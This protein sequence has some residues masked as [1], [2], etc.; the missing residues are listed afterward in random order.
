MITIVLML[1]IL[2]QL[3]AAAM[4]LRLIPLT[5]KRIAWT[6]IAAALT[7]MAL[8]RSI[9]FYRLLSGSITI[10]P[11]FGAEI[12]ALSISILMVVGISKI[13]PIF[14]AGAKSKE[15]LEKANRE[16]ETIFEAIGHSALILDPRHRIIAANR[17]ILKA[18]G[19]TEKEVLGRTCH[20]I[21]H[22]G[23]VSP[24]EHCPANKMTVSGRMEQYD[25]EID[26]LGGVF[27]VT[28]TPV[29]D[30][31]GQIRKIIH[32]ATDI[33]ERKR[34]E[35]KLREAYDII[36]GSPVVAFLWKNDE[37]W[38]VEFVT[39]NVKNL[40]GYEAEELTSGTV[41]YAETVHPDD[42]ETVIRE[43]SDYSKEK[44]RVA[45]DHK[46]YRI[47]TKDGTIKWVN[48][49]T[50]IRRNEKGEITYYQ[51]ILFDITESKR[52]ETALRES[53]IKYRSLVESSGDL[54]YAT[55]RKG[56]LTYVN[57]TLEKILG[58]DRGQLK[59]TPFIRITAPGFIDKAKEIFKQAMRGEN[60]PV[61]EGEL[62]GKDGTRIIVEFNTT[63]LFDSD[64]TFSGR[65]GIGRDITERRKMERA[66]LQ[67][68][69]RYKTYVENSFAGVYVVQKGR[70]V[71]LNNNA[72]SFVGYRPEEL[73]G[74][75]PE[76]IV[77]PE[78]RVV[79]R[80]RAIKALKEKETLPY[81]FRVVTKDGRI[82]WIME[83]VTSI[84]YDGGSAVLGNSMDI[85]ERKEAEE[86]LGIREELEKSI[87]LSVPHA[88]FGVEKRRIFFANAAMEDVFGWKPEELIG[89][90]TRVIFRNDEEWE[91]YDSMIYSG[92]KEMPV[93]RFESDMPFVRKD[94]SEIY[95]RTSVSRVG[96]EL[97][98]TGRIVA[99]FEDVT[100]Q[101]KADEERKKLE[102][103]LH[104]AQKMEAIGTLAGGIAHDF[105]NLLMT[106]QGNASMMLEDVD[107][108][109][110]FYEYLKSI[111]KQIRSAANLTRQL[112]GFARQGHYDIKS[113]D[114][115]YIV[116][117]NA[118]MFAR[119]KKEIQIHYSLGDDLWTVN[120]DADQMG[121]VLMN[122]FVNAWQAMPG[123]GNL[124]IGTANVVLDKHYV[125]PYSTVPGRYVKISVTDSGVGMNGQT[126]LRIFEPFFTTKER[127]Q[128]TGLGLAMVYGIIKAHKGFVNVYSEPGHGTTFNIFLPASE[129]E[130]VAEAAAPS[131][132]V[133]GTGTILLVDD[134]AQVLAVSLKM[135]KYLGYR[136]IAA[137]NGQEAVD[138][139]GRMKGEI[140]LVLLD[141]VMPEMSGGKVFQLLREINPNVKVILLS[142]YSVDGQAKEIM[143]QGCKGFI[144]KPA[145]LGELSQKI[146]EVL[147]AEN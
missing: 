129:Q 102:A 3:V 76:R 82:R 74:Q 23:V 54:I 112:L 42:I 97:G 63:S 46:P 92:L 50:L 62:I 83:S 115:N 85:T 93:L 95:C 75:Q 142:G 133:R 29:F 35:E 87:F 140:D 143:D 56:V 125:K 5:G 72:A 34:T 58:Y 18:L 43:V 78:D 48:D 109:H 123:G 88:L 69:E 73:I 28:C 19:M 116:E 22:T 90:S 32:I 41:S 61:Y 38:P 64:G 124:F 139:Y 20:E 24:P 51:G 66:L 132:I 67:S 57:P 118:S 108:S 40:F 111:E 122:L 47:V 147:K 14:I 107:P 146:D 86:E 119:T 89:E 141:M 114:I 30:E 131:G 136:A 71:F 134:E 138:L 104:Q 16:W 130:T 145:S 128:G 44:D 36:N 17:T 6:L 60:I 99:S 120:A 37:G 137:Q 12:V 13:A 110:P 8:R 59:G 103:Q 11:D 7:L 10:Q 80:A 91:E 121:Q 21:Y 55:D 4:A 52:S 31:S 15:Q 98:P 101:K 1:S 9:T 105:N 113:A 96:R 33:S 53:E 70:F 81:E 106:M 2:F 77:H 65:Y 135:L 127:G 79:T 117:K 68:E 25:M 26:A 100:E 45:F 39:D 126:V 144:Q 94:G 27:H 84:Q 49:S